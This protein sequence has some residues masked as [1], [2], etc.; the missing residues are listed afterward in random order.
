MKLPVTRRRMIQVAG[1]GALAV[2]SPRVSAAPAT[3]WPIMEGP[4][5]PK[6]GLGI[7]IGRLNEATARKIKQLG[8]NYVRSA[9]AATQGSAVDAEPGVGEDHEHASRMEK[10]G[11]YRAQS[12]QRHHLRLRSHQRDGRGSRGSLPLFHEEGLYQSRPFS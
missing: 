3:N 11:G 9:G 1:A 6:L 12:A 7:G 2:R 10:A 5:T 8:V 4:N